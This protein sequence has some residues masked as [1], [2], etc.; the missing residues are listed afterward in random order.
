MIQIT[1]RQLVARMQRGDEAAF[2]EFFE[3]HFAPLYRFALPRVG[4]DADVA[5]EVVQATLSRAVRKLHTFRGEAALL[6][7][8]C[9]FCRHEISAHYEKV[10]SMPQMVNLSDDSTE[11]R[12]ALES[13]GAEDSQRRSDTARLVQV[14][15]DRLPD[16][17]GDALEWKYIEGLSVNEIAMRLG[18]G[19]KAAESLLT[20]ARAAFRDAFT[21]VYG[22]Q[23][24]E[25]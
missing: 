19:A 1:D 2:G 25:V 16:R 11:I 13:L 15:L 4:G 8:L 3:G 17:Y 9:T 24:S 23:W 6:T 12:A 5:E 18:V 14:V 21:A 22:G 10:G 20:R 7:W